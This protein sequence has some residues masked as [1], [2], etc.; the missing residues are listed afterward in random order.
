[1]GKRQV[2]RGTSPS[3][4]VKECTTILY[5][6]NSRAKTPTLIFSLLPIRALPLPYSSIHA[7]CTTAFPAE[8]SVTGLW[9]L[10]GTTSSP[11]RG[12][13]GGRGRRQQRQSK[14]RSS[15]YNLILCFTLV[16]GY[17]RKSLTFHFP[18]LRDLYQ[19]NVAIWKQALNSSWNFVNCFK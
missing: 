15:T 12:G 2:G 13:M 7:P 14:L 6:T 16:R 8:T 11:Q 10:E 1:M 9:L 4:N 5:H 19:L 3:G 17:I 18:V